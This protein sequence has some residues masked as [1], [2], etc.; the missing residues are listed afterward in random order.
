MKKD[1]TA[2]RSTAIVT[3]ASR[4][5]GQH[6]ARSL[7]RSGYRLILTARSGQ[8][9]EALADDL[10]ASGAQAV[11]VAA[12]VTDPQGQDRII[13]AAESDGGRIDVLV[14][15]AGGDP[16]REFEEMTWEENEAILRLNLLAPMELT[17]KLLPGMVSRGKG[18]VVNISAIAGRVGFPYLEAYAAAKDGLIAFTRVL[19]NDFRASGV[20][21]SAVILGAIRDAGQGQRTSDEMGVVLPKGA[22]SPADAVGSA[23]ARAIEKDQAEVVVMPG[24]GRL[25]KALLDLFPRLGAFLNRR[26][27]ANDTMRAVINF[28]KR[29][30]RG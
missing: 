30:R 12:D 3:G 2:A 8:E 7:A 29:N 17:H 1:T 24:P 5:I 15:N 14:N 16:Q 11:A 9:L 18:H 25:L 27:G 6:I 21:S 19:R 26:T 23:V 22:T 4:G 20:S 13:R 10:R 28:R